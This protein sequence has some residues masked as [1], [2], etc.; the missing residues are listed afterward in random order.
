[1]SGARE[2]NAG[3]EL[4]PPIEPGSPTEVAQSPSVDGSKGT[5]ANRPAASSSLSGR[6]RRA[7]RSFEQS[8]LPEGFFAATGG[9]A[10][11]ILSRQADPRPFSSYMSSPRARPAVPGDNTSQSAPGHRSEE[12]Q[13]ESKNDG[14]QGN[15]KIANCKG[16]PPSAAPFPNGYHFPPKHSFGE[17]AKLGFLA[18]WNYFLTPVGFA[19]TIYGLNVVAWGGMLFLLLCNAAPAMCYPSCNDINSPRRKWIE[20]DSQILN[21]LFCVTGFGLAPWRF[22]DLYF[23]LQYRLAKKERALRRLAGIHR[24]WFRLGGSNELPAA[25][26]PQNVDRDEFQSVSR[27]AIPFPE[28]K[29]PEAPLTEVRA[30]PTLG[31]KL[32]LVIWLMVANTFLQCVLSG[33]MWGM[34]RYSRPSWATGLFVALGCGVA[35]IGGFIMFLEGKTVKSIEGVPLSPA[36]TERLERDREQGV[37]HFNNIQDKNLDVIDRIGQHT[38]PPRGASV[39]HFPSSC[40]ILRPRHLLEHRVLHCHTFG[41]TKPPWSVSSTHS[42]RP[43]AIKHDVTSSQIPGD[44]GLSYNTYLNADKIYGCKTCKTHLANHEDIISRNFRGQ[45]GK[46]YL[47]HRVVNIEAG[48]PNERNMTTGRH[49]VRDITCRQ[50]KETVGWKYDKAYEP[51][52]KYKEGKFILEAELLCNVT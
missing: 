1:M 36:D 34:N 12:G 37:W 45:H 6:L 49:L 14:S 2:N 21:A 9:L 11:S 30:R 46:A 31:W 47:F 22:R 41:S 18:F 27:S 38:R 52:E 7:S 44:M 35:G 25:L 15:Q 19:V 50:C 29:I 40:A 51:S 32:D 23:L 10:S 24:G 33:F 4:F 26:G 39:Y 13:A 3:V 16:E 28:T 48:E 43:G 8:E 42:P 20:V 5:G 17:S